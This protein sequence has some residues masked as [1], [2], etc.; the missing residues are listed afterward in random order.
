MEQFLVKHAS[1]VS[2][3]EFFG[4]IALASVLEC[5][6]PKER[7][8]VALGLRWFGNIA[9]YIVDVI[10][11]RLLFPFLGL[12]FAILCAEKGWGLFN[13]LKLPW[14]LEFA[15]TLLLLNL[16]NYGLHY[17]FHHVTPL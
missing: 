15:L 9:I 7:S 5:V 13:H 10:A 17:L 12:G 1:T 3:Y 6:V 14:W 2:T 11:S 16:A 8:S 4:I